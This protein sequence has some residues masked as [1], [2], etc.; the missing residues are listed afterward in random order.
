[1]LFYD[2]DGIKVETL[3]LQDKEK[4]LDYYAKDTLDCNYEASI[5]KINTENF[6]K[7]IDDL[8]LE[9]TDEINIF[10]LKKNDQVIG[11]ETMYID[12]DRLHIGSIII[13]KKEQDK[14]YD[15]LLIR[16]AVLV[17]ENDQRD[18]SLYCDRDNKCLEKIGFKTTDNIYYFY[19]KIGLKIEWYPKIFASVDEYRKRYNQKQKTDIKSMILERK[20]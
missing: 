19:E 7:I 8:V 18:V 3:K 2:R 16:L 13:D 14:G 20:I 4:V 1:M 10:V 6:R 12:C 5:L 17:A 9:K 15:E 11:Y